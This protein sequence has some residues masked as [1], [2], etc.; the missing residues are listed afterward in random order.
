MSKIET[1]L[2]NNGD[3]IVK[4]YNTFNQLHNEVGPAVHSHGFEIWYKNGVK[5]RKDGF[6]VLIK[7]DDYIRVE[8]W[9]EGLLH[10]I[11]KPAIV[12]S[13]GIVEYWEIGVKL[14]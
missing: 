13:N 11:S 10:R 1:V 5:H 9:E 6:A 12:D 7:N 2:L 4:H 8:Y 3:Q 14:N